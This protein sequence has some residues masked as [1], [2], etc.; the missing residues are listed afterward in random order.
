MNDLYTIV[1][2][3]GKGTRM[4]SKR[5]KVLQTLAGKPL[6]SHVLESCARLSSQVFVVYG[7]EGDALQEAYKDAPLRWVHQSAQLGT[8]HAVLQVLPHLPKTGKSLILYGD[9]PLICPRTLKQMA[10]IDAP[11][12]ILTAKK[13]DPFGL[14]RIV[15]KEGKVVG[16]TEEKDACDKVRA[17]KE[18]NSGIYCVDNALLHRYLPAISNQN[19]QSEYYLTDLVDLA[20]KDGLDIQTQE[21]MHLF[22]IEGVNDRHQ[23][24]RLER[25]YQRHLVDTLARDGVQFLDPMRC[26]IR[27]RLVCGVDV[28]IDVGAVFLGEVVLG[29]GVHIG[30]GCVIC[31]SQIEAHSHI[32]PYSVIT[33]ARLGKGVQIGP[34]AHLRNKSHIQDGAKIG[35]FVETKNTQIGQNSKANHLSYLG[36][37]QIGA[38][39]NVGA[40]VITCNYDG[41][42]KH[43]TWIEDGAFIG[44]NSA[45]IAPIRIGT[46][47]TIGAGSTLTKDAK[48]QTLTLTRADTIEHTDY[49]RPKKE[50]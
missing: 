45:L 14:G 25:T 46:Q 34:F 33:G 30:A 23:L 16:I 42:H 4:H 26:D 24:S 8:G 41:A 32:A 18:I 3:A 9:V 50:D 20:A 17:I 12:V 19:A 35:N 37:C 1:L 40:G 10:S 15:R 29:D 7:F 44:S 22:E 43:T 13:S 48:A 28:V 31:D 36:D 47:A 11:L 5:P 49:T 2:A 38:G 39:V 6:L 21:P 27:G